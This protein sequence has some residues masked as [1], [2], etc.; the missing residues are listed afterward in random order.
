MAKTKIKKLKNMK[1]ITTI[2]ILLFLSITGIFWGYQK[3]NLLFSGK[4]DCGKV[5][6]D[7]NKKNELFSVKLEVRNEEGALTPGACYN[8]TSK[9]NLDNH[10]IKIFSVQFDDIISVN[11]ENISFVSDKVGFVYLGNM[12][13]LT[14]DAGNSW[15]VWDSE[16]FLDNYSK[17]NARSIEAVKVSLDGQGEMYLYKHPKD[18]ETIVLETSNYGENWK[19]VTE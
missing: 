7:I 18:N 15:K 11:D 3:N 9:N 4:Y 1:L 5:I 6:E 10:R 8:F 16:V 2:I 14:M 19:L 12:F 13:A 17:I